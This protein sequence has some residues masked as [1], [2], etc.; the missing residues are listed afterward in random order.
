EAGAGGRLEEQGA[1][2]RPR[3]RAAVVGALREVL[4]T[5]EQCLDPLARQAFERE[6][7]FHRGGRRG[8]GHAGF[9]GGVSAAGAIESM[10][11]A[12][13]GAASQRSTITA[14]ATAS[15]ASASRR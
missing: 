10:S 7:V 15:S 8:V 2:R 5:L 1:H 4:C 6:Q 14:A 9:R 13:P 12:S 3:Q 11:T